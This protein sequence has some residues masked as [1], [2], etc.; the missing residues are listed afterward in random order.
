V[1]ARAAARPSATLTPCP[2]V[3]SEFAAIH[4]LCM[5]ALENSHKVDLIRATLTTLH[6]YLSWV[7]L[8]YIF[9]ARFFFCCSETPL[10]RRAPRARW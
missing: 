7:P 1:R 10:S 9:E 4:E 3:R 2:P 6:A 5:F 8:G